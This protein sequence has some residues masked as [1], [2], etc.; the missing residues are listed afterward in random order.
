M[1]RKLPD[2]LMHCIH[3]V[4]PLNAL[5]CRHVKRVSRVGTSGFDCETSVLQ[6]FKLL[7]VCQLSKIKP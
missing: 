4:R 7:I 6:D 5:L 1:C 3:F 2:H